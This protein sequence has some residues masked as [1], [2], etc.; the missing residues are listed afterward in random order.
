MLKETIFAIVELFYDLIWLFAAAVVVVVACVI[1]VVR[2][3]L[4]PDLYGLFLVF[5]VLYV[6]TPVWAPIIFGITFF[7]LWLRYIRAEYI[8]KQGAVL[9]EIKLPRETV[10]SP[11]AM[12][13]FFTSL[14]QTGTAA[15]YID[16]FWRGKVR[17][18]FSLEL[19]S[20][21]GKVKFFIWCHTKFRNLV[22]AQLYAQYPNI[23]IHE[24]EDYMAWFH[25]PDPVNW[26]MWA[27]YFKFMKPN[28]YPI[29][30][31]VDYG[32]DKLDTKE[33]YKVDPM[34]SI[35]EYLGS[36]KKGEHVWIQIIIQAHRKLSLKND[37]VLLG[38]EDWKE[39]VREE[40]EKIRKESIV[41]KPG[42]EFPGMP[43]PTKGQ[44]NTIAALERSVSKWPFEACIRGIY[45]A[46]KDSFDPISITGL[47]GTFRQYS[48]ND[49]VNG[50]KLGWFTDFDYPW[51]DFRRL[52][53]TQDERE[54]LEAIK[55]R[56]FFQAPFKNFHQSPII[57]NTEELATIY[58]FPGS[59][60][61]TPSF[62]RIPS[63]RTEAPANLPI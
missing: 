6:T 3:H 39:E 46:H 14:Y 52:R 38:K 42:S 61:A 63:K 21:E 22:E 45:I 47:I 55:Q 26:P 11:L 12:E 17:P 35:L 8:K 43:N 15:G 48:S 1:L 41:E 25:H 13:I 29:K 24:A 51:Q 28:I 20:V 40:I 18:W 44:Q 56:S 16:S 53:R 4:S 36:M 59:V 32:L 62:E 50:F 33:E 60:A 10:K 23:E 5:N 57:L 37:G 2:L 30:T 9:L 34:T 54:M 19:V 49:D 7:N 31:Y 27:T 58:H